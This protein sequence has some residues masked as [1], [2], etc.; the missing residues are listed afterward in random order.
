[1]SDTQR[2][3]HAPE[4]ARAIPGILP[5]NVGR[6]LGAPSAEPTAPVRDRSSAWLV[7]AAVGLAVL[8]GAAAT[9]NF[10]AQYQMVHAAR[11]LPAIAAL[12]A[13]IPDTAAL[14]FA[15]LGIALALHGRRAVRSRLLNLAS[16]ATSVAMNILAAAPGWRDLAIWAMPPIAYA[17]AS[18]TL[19]G[20]VRATTIARHQAL[21]RTS[22]SDDEP[23]PLAVIGATLLWL[24]RLTIAPLSTLRGLRA[25][26]IAECPAA[27]RPRA[28]CPAPLAVPP[29]SAPAAQRAIRPRERRP[30][31][32]RS[33]TKTARFL[34]LVTEHHGPLARIQLPSVSRICADLAPEIG[35]NTGA[36]RTALRKA[37]LSAQNG[38]P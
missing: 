20:V 31:V 4:A 26:I 9:V 8:A 5:A 35:L 17:L 11:G 34:A 22:T 10:S 33:G 6:D 16:V 29:P 13:A 30:R 27:P 19:I 37:V 2:A 18:D 23:T 28:T 15:S 14:I 38:T 36:A 1:M 12:E 3:T 21:R 25:W 7:T 24:I 32:G